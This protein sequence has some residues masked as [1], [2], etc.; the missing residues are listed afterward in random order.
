MCPNGW[1]WAT[2]DP[3]YETHRIDW[4]HYGSVNFL[5]GD[6]SVHLLP[7]DGAEVLVRTNPLHA[8]PLQRG[9]R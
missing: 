3:S 6:D 7:Q 8:D 5:F 9:Y 1:T 2:V 4:S